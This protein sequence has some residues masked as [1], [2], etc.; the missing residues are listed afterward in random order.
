LL[1][2]RPMFFFPAAGGARNQLHPRRDDAVPCVRG[3]VRAPT[4]ASRA[5]FAA[6]ELALELHPRASQTD[7]GAGER[8]GHESALGARGLGLERATP[9]C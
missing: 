2:Y 9:A 4:G 5:V 7:S 1:A 6:G 8:S 3:S